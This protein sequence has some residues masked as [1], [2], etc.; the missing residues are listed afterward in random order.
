MN[1]VKKTATSRQ[2]K[3]IKGDL[4][5]HDLILGLVNMTNKYR[6]YIYICMIL[7]DNIDNIIYAYISWN[8]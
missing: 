5:Y 4:L 3:V 8:E 2:M 7:Y 1:Y 6:V